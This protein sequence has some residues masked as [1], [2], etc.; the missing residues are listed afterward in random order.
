MF[1]GRL[2]NRNMSNDIWASFRPLLSLVFLLDYS[3]L[4]WTDYF[5]FWSE[6][7]FYVCVCQDSL[8]LSLSTVCMWIAW[9]RI[10]LFIW[11][12]FGYSFI[13]LCSRIA[14]LNSLEIR[15]DPWSPGS[16]PLRTNKKKQR[17]QLSLKF[18]C[19]PQLLRGKGSMLL[20]L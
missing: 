3:C 16:P 4:N 8:V 11:M 12:Y 9:C 7:Y 20:V 15:R 14:T 18:D 2:L 10:F 19:L 5:Y 17:N 1:G 13:G 6:L